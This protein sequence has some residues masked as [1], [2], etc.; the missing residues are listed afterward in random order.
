MVYGVWCDGL[1]YIYTFFKEDIQ[2]AKKQVKICSTSLIIGE[3]QI[4]T[5]MR[6]HLTLVRTAIIKNLQTINAGKSVEKRELSYTV[7]GNVNRCNHYEE[8]YG[9][10]FKN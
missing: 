6:Y 4:K 7:V 2:V 10:A 5:T 3:M 8:Q 9:D 1:K